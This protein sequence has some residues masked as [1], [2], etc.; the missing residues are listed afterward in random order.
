[1]LLL[2]Y[3]YA[4]LSLH[5]LSPPHQ[6]LIH[7]LMLMAAASLLPIAPPADWKPD[8]SMNPTLLILSVLLGSVGLP[9]FVLAANGPLMQAWFIRLF[10]GKSPYPPIRPLQSRIPLGPDDL[11]LCGGTLFQPQ[12]TNLWLDLRVHGH[13]FQCLMVSA[14]L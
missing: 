2:G 6:V 3:A 12:A 1:M 8:D 11:S 10:P 14:D 5:R 13:G 4:H 9:Y 7:V